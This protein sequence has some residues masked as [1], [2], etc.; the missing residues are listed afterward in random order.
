MSRE[1][2]LPHISFVNECFR[3][4]GGDVA[5]LLDC[6]KRRHR[7]PHLE[8]V[9]RVCDISTTYCMNRAHGTYVARRMVAE[10]NDAYVDDNKK[11]KSGKR[12]CSRRAQR[13]RHDPELTLQP[14][15]LPPPY[16]SPKVQPNSP[17]HFSPAFRTHLP[18]PT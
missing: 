10:A 7:A 12:L 11:K 9:A 2:L 18:L 6:H 14:P 1:R 16:P 5:R 13:K 4:C 3:L 17:P 15:T 8:S